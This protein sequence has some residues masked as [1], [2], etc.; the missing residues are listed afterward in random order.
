MQ[1]EETL[2]SQTIVLGEAMRHYRAFQVPGIDVLCDQWLFSTA[3]QAQSAAH[4]M[5]INQVTS[6]LY[7][8]TNWDFDFRGHKQQGDW[9]AAL[10]ITHRVHHLA[11]ASL[12]G[13]AKRDYPASIF[14]QSPW[15]NQYKVVE[16]YFARINTAL[17]TGDPI[18]RIAV[19]HP[20]ESYWLLHGPKEQTSERRQKMEE[21]FDQITHWL[22]CGALDFDFISEGLMRG[23]DTDADEKGLQVG[24][25][26]YDSV[27]VPGCLTLRGTTMNLLE[28]FR[29]AGGKVLFVGDIPTMVDAVESDRPQL[30]AQ[31]AEC[32]EFS[33]L[34]ITVTVPNGFWNQRAVAE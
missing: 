13:E 4:Q 1:A 25:M 21:Q 29:A 6:E 24:K 15:Y 2:D 33:R 12:G 31:K 8:V 20:I 19:I 23:F 11:L 26:S 34:K 9:Q 22:L 7:G 32:V 18:E 5:G 3:K 30:L 16:D 14:Y 28:K 17:R 10:G 27:V